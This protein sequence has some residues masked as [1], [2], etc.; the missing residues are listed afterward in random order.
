MKMLFEWECWGFGQIVIVIMWQPG[1]GQEHLVEWEKQ[2]SPHFD[3]R[4]LHCHCSMSTMMMMQ[5]EQKDKTRSTAAAFDNLIHRVYVHSFVQNM[6]AVVN[7][8][9]IRPERA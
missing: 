3:T 6:A 1:L 5:K 2:P 9:S 4:H 7:S 8:R